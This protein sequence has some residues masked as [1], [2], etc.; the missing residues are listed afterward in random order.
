[1]D[2]VI[3]NGMLLDESGALQGTVGIKNGRI[4]TILDTDI[5]PEA[6]EVID[7]TGMFVMPGMIDAH[8]HLE[9]PVS[10]TVSS[11]D[12][13][14]GSVAAAFGGVT[15][16]ID[17]A[18]Q[19]EGESLIKSIEKRRSRADGNVAVDYSLHCAI[20]TW[21]EKIRREM[22]KVVKYG[23][24]SFKLFMI[25]E[26]RGWMADDGILFECF[27][28][29]AELDAVVAVHAENPR[30]IASF[31]KKA[32]ASGGKGAILHALSRPD[33]SEA[34]AVQRAIYL[35]S[36]SD[37]KVYI[38]HMTTR[39]ACEIVE[40]WQH[41]G[42]PVAAETCPQFLV[43]TDSMYR[44]KNGH[45]FATCPP[46]RSEEDSDYLW[47]AIENGSVQV[48]ATDHC[49][50]TKKQKDRW[51]GDF[52]KI[53]FGIP[54]VE[55]LLPIVF[56]HGLLAGRISAG[57]MVQALASNPAKIFGLYP[58]KGTI[59]IGSDA[60]LIMIDP[61]REIRISPG[62]LHMNCDFSPYNGFRLRGFPS[63]TML[64]GKIVQKDG[65]FTGGRGDGIFLKRC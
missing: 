29:A 5:V 41:Q 16:I 27:R 25:Y 64:R 40:E 61:E 20:T 15:T 4:A 18:T 14:S 10:G 59:R 52:R 3:I 2:T 65:R 13:R 46:L 37:A 31:T 33:F 11:D 54:G 30:I 55:T 26:D 21:N 44:R 19:V 8:V 45:Y 39:Q 49:S 56:T 6:R 12:F 17:F 48:V 23:I 35:A 57:A 60:D 58:R 47:D 63:L 22:A 28:Q 42:Y 34:E 38:V 36:M 43:L 1:M 51:R 7:A 32:L 53:P 24:S 50:F 62:R 9:L